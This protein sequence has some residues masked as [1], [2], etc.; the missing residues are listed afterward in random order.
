MGGLGHAAQAGGSV[1]GGIAVDDIKEA[2]VGSPAVG[3]EHAPATAA[4]GGLRGL[5]VED[6]GIAQG[7]G[8][9]GVD[10]NVT[11]EN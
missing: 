11:R 8:C 1:D 10:S 2:H 7:S 9:R 5:E 3:F 6:R 4:G